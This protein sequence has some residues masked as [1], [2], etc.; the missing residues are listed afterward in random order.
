MSTTSIVILNAV[1]MFGIVA[2]I[3]SLCAGAIFT[4]PAVE[5]R[6]RRSIRLAHPRTASVRRSTT[7]GAFVRHP[8]YEA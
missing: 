1:L 5:R 2:A 7:A 4:S 8:F 6:H 3:V